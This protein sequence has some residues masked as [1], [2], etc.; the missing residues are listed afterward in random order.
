MTEELQ[1]VLERIQI[2]N[3]EMT[4]EKLIETLFENPLF[5]YAVLLIADN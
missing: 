1:P 4:M 5:T 2:L 3:P